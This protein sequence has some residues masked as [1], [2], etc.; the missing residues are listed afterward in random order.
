V[1]LAIQGRIRATSHFETFSS[2]DRGNKWR[3]SRRRSPMNRIQSAYRKP[4][5]LH[6]RKPKAHE[7]RENK[8][9]KKG[10]K[11]IKGEAYQK[12]TRARGWYLGEL[13][14]LRLLLLKLLA[15]EGLLLGL[16]GL[17]FPKLGLSIVAFRPAASSRVRR[18]DNSRVRR[19]MTASDSA[20]SSCSMRI[21]SARSWSMCLS[22][23]FVICWTSVA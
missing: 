6:P 18:V 13:A 8:K 17:V 11:H 2:G 21:L 19:F 9:E 7:D 12:S 16:L 14:P 1:C 22:K 3:N 4:R 10:R 20:S 5:P 15:R 23:L